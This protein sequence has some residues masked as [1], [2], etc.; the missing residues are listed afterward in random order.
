MESIYTARN[1]QQIPFASIANIANGGIFL[2]RRAAAACVLAR[3]D[4]S[5]QR[6]TLRAQPRL[7]RPALTAE[8]SAWCFPAA[9]AFW[10]RPTITI[11]SLG[12]FTRTI[13]VNPVLLPT[14]GLNQ[15]M[16]AVT[17]TGQL[18]ES[19]LAA[20]R[21]VHGE[22]IDLELSLGAQTRTMNMRNLEIATR[23]HHCWN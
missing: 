14:G 11:M 19:W 8:P 9:T 3:M 7:A 21:A 23:L 4:L 18:Y 2:E 17:I 1:S 20:P 16:M 10:E 13:T 22:R 12:N 15:N 6:M 5:E